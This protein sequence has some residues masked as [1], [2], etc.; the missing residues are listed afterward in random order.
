M[1]IAQIAPLYESC[2]PKLYGGTER[3]VSYLTEDLVAAG[4]EVT[5]F[6]SGDSVTRARLLAPSERAIRLAGAEYEGLADHSIMFHRVA[7]RLDEFDI[8]HFHTDFMHFAAFASLAPKT[9]TTIHGRVDL[10]VLSRVFEEFDMMPL[11]SISDA[12]R[13]PIPNAHWVR[14]IP[15]GLP[16]DLYRL[17][18]GEG[19]YLAF[20]GRMSFEKRPDR[21]I[22]IA[23]AAGVPLRMAAKIDKVDNEYYDTKI[24]HLIDDPLVD[25]IGEIGDDR[26]NEFYGNA[27]GLVFPIDWP[28]PFGLVMIEAMST[29]TP[30]IAFRHGSVEEVIEDGL[31]G[32]IVDTVDEAV[33]AVAKLPTLDRRAIRRRFE[34]RFTIRRV[35]EAYVD[36]YREQLAATRVHEATT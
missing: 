24:A 5:L 21:A 12:Q 4:H 26:K 25:Y 34:E 6:A 9:L 28:E 33:A 7:Q 3:V 32:F 17:G 10:P 15:H 13:L 19:G 16:A 29:G 35:T 22:E 23:K 27:L 20:V 31:T 1:R 36:L 14:T 30:T 8:L 2:P 11:V 18:S